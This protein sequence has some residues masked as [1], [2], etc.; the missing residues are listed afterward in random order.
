MSRDF[1]P[2]ATLREM[3]ADAWRLWRDGRFRPASVG[4]GADRALRPEV[5][6]DRILWVDPGTASPAL[7]AYLA[8][9]EG[10]RR[11]LNAELFLGLETVEAQLAVFPAGAFYRKHLDRFAQSGERAISAVLYLNAAWRPQ[12]GGAL[13]LHLDEGPVEVLPEMGTLAVFRSDTVWHEVLE[14][15]APRLSATGWFRRR[16]TLPVP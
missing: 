14:A 9:M 15:A 10:L 13:R 7:G 8:A 4:Q 1:L 16:P 2:E 12:D 5:R 3:A 6:G 11:G